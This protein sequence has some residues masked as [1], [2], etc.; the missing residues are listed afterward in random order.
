MA[1]PPTLAKEHSWPAS[2]IKQ[3]R[4]KR[5]QADF[6]RLLGVP[7]NTVL[8]WEAGQVKPNSTNAE[9][10]STLAEKEQFLADW[11]LVGSIIILGDIEEGSREI[12]E[13]MQEAIERS[14][15]EFEAEA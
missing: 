9:H 7:K 15:Q 6:G 10:L 2:L 1:S 12:S 5:T 3:L 4:G 11:N 8:R 14:I 13:Q